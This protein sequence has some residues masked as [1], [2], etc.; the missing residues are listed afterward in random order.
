MPYT[1]SESCSSCNSCRVDCPTNAIQFNNG[2]Y[3]IDQKLCNN[4][5]GYYTEPQCIVQCPISSPIPI[6]PKKGRY[7]NITRDITSPELFINR[8]NTPFASSMIIWEACTVL[9]QA[10]VLNWEKDIQGNLYYKRF[11][12]QGEGTILFRLNDV[13]D[14]RPSGLVRYLTDPSKLN[15][16]DI[17]SACLHLLFSAYATTLERPWEQKFIINDQQIEQYLGLDKRKDISKT[18]KLTLIKLLLQQTC[19]LLAIINWPQ[20]GKVKR[21]TIPEGPLWHLLDI[22]HYF[23]EDDFGCQHL[24]GLTFT[25][26]AGIWSKY[27]LNKQGYNNRIAFY[28]YGSLPQFILSTVMS[29][30]QQHPGAIR[31]LLWLLFKSKMGRKQCVTVP[32]LMKVAYGQDRVLQADIKRNQRKKILKTFEG[33]LEVLNHYGVKAVFDPISYPENIQPLWVKVSKL[34]DD[35]EEALNFWINDG[36]QEH[37]LTDSG[38]R[39]KWNW[40]MKARILNFEL[41]QE[42]EE[43]LIKFERKKQQKNSQKNRVKKSSQLSAEKIQYARKKKGLSQR[44]LAK[45]VGKSQS[46]IRDLEKGRCSAKAEDRE[47]LQSIL[48]L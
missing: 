6:H 35:A 42:W 10:P 1:I 46:W 47:N 25:L 20:Q 3:W 8:K 48:E 13:L 33:D 18:T 23:Q 24:I 29:I 34:P 16:I 14:S 12:K 39:G 44:A 17:R 7:K 28:Q 41:P 15:F 2:K 37:R 31:I 40:L 21:F 26:R 43:E 36:S 45:Q 11:V 22:Q 5:Q 30:W 27:F 19:Q 38:P 4:C 9:T 32:T